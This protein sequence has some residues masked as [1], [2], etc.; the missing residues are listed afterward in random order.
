MC[1]VASPLGACARHRTE[2]G[3][4]EAV[5]IE[6]V[7]VIV[8]IGVTEYAICKALFMGIY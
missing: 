5:R 2:L 8:G 4:K 7:R 3:L 1:I 6:G